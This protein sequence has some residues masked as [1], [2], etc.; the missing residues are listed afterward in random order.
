MKTFG[1]FAILILVVSLFGVVAQAAPGDFVTDLRVKVNGVNADSNLPVRLERGQQVAVEVFFTGNPLGRCQVG[2]DNPCYDTRVEVE[3]QGYEYS[4]VRD[5]E[6]PFEVEPGVPDR[7]VLMFT[8][9]DDMPASDNLNLNVEIKDDD[10]LVSV[11]YPVRIQEVRH[12][13][14]IFDAIF[15][16][17]NNVRAGQPLFTTLRVENLG[18]NLESSAKVTVAIPALGIQTSEF[19]DRLGTVQNNQ[20][21]D[22]EVDDASTTSDLLLFIPQ[23]TLEGNY[24]VVVTLEYNRG[25][26]TEERTYTMHVVGSE[27]V[28]NVPETSNTGVLVNVESETLKVNAGEGAIYRFSVA[29][30]G[31]QASNF[32]LEV[33]GANSWANVRVDPMTLTVQPNGAEDVFVFVA[34]KEGV[35]GL[36]AFNVKVLSGSQVI[37]DSQL[38]LEVVQAENTVSSKQVFTWIF[39]VLLAILV[40]LVIVVLVKK[41][42]SKQG[43]VESQTYY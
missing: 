42:S 21:E 40:I 35:T 4:E 11:V 32:R 5:V 19:V 43:G 2:E 27:Q 39:V 26:S 29:N 10:E 12:R 31:R 37:N 13:L 20:D 9:P 36:K 8:L 16:P 1:L 34:P 25:F 28:Q 3:I 23:G 38:T 24:D 6:G 30:L 7:K 15:N 41:A 14:N 33:T 22:N 17:I 18:D